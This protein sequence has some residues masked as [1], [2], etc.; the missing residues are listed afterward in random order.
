MAGSPEAGW[1]RAWECRRGGDPGGVR[2][3]E[4]IKRIRKR[5]RQMPASKGAESSA[6]PGKAP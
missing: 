2:L 6:T 5:G 4:K 1:G 3:G